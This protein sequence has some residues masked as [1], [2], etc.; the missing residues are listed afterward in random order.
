MTHLGTRDERTFF[1]R[2]QIAPTMMHP[3]LVTRPP[4]KQTETP[5]AEASLRTYTSTSCTFSQR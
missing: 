3:A 4:A 5:R 1:D 2:A